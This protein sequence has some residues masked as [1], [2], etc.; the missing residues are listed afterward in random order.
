MNPADSDFTLAVVTFNAVDLTG[1][2]N[3]PAQATSDISFSNSGD[4][5]TGAFH[6]TPPLDAPVLGQAVPAA[7]IILQPVVDLILGLELPNPGTITGDLGE[8]AFA[9][10]ETIYI[11]IQVETF[12]QGVDT[13]DVFLDFDTTTLEAVSIQLTSDLDQLLGPETIDNDAGNVAFSVT[14]SGGSVTGNFDL[15]VVTFKTKL[16]TQALNVGFSQEFPRRTEVAFQGVPVLN[17]LVQ[18]QPE[19][20]LELKITTFVEGAICDLYCAQVNILVRPNGNRIDTVD[21]LLDFTTDNDTQITS[22]NLGERFEVELERT[23]D[24]VLGTVDVAMSTVGDT[25]VEEFSL[26]VVGITTDQILLS[27]DPSVPGTFE[28]SA[29]FPRISQPAFDSEPV[30]PDR[31][32]PLQ[33][34]FA[35]LTGVEL[36]ADAP[37]ALPNVIR[38]TANIDNTPIFQWDPPIVP[39][40]AGIQTFEITIT[41]GGLPVVDFDARDVADELTCFDIVGTPIACFV[42]NPFN[43]L[44]F[45]QDR[46]VW[47]RFIVVDEPELADGRYEFSVRAVDNLGQR[48]IESPEVPA[49]FVIDTEPPDI[50]IPT[51]KHSQTD[52]FTNDESPTLEWAPSPDNLTD[53]ID[54]IYQVRVVTTRDGLA[55]TQFI[56]TP[57]GAI[58]W[59]IFG[60]LTNQLY[61]WDVRSLGLDRLSC[62]GRC[63]PLTQAAQQHD[64]ESESSPLQFEGGCDKIRALKPRWWN[65]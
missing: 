56:D 13:V 47:V 44:V 52:V 60:L 57:G 7:V 49:P 26:A 42:P 24:P 17:E 54:I 55:T 58:E 3:P 63:S 37:G 11:P 31:E 35:L 51:G 38:T 33:Q 45:D 36:R 62:C 61:W 20:A 59:D 18:F 41:S 50:P 10:K 46:V 64:H 29:D 19:L 8:L 27:D 30:P 16:A 21:A 23:W 43:I 5:T 1:G 65:W 9:R 48:G 25:P 34:R 28:F 4:R 12:G 2:I 14:S 15:A 39:P 40:P 32:S 53:A 6:Q 22:I